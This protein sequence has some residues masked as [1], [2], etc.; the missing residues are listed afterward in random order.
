V[1]IVINSQG[2]VITVIPKWWEVNSKCI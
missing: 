1:K 2:K